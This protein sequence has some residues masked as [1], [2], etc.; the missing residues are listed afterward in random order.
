MEEKYKVTAGTIARTVILVLALVNQI[1]SGTGHP[2]IPIPD[3]TIEGTVSYI[4]T[5]VVALWTYWKNN[6]WTRPALM[7]DVLMNRVRKE[8]KEQKEKGEQK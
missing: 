7:G 6:S 8:Q 1:L 5:V 2:V 4:V 3:E